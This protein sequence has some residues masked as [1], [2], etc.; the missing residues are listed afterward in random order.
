M[1]DIRVLHFLGPVFKLGR[2]ITVRKGLKWSNSKGEIVQVCVCVNE[3]GRL[4]HYP[5]YKAKITETRVTS[6]IDIMAS[7]LADEHDPTCRNRLGLVKAM[8]RAYPDFSVNDQVT[9]V[10]FELTRKNAQ[11]WERW[12]EQ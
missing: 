6:F 5:V 3:D 1:R 8:E 7:E 10:G 2:N 11:I 9:V 4:V 12:L